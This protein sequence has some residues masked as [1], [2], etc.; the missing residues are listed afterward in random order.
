MATKLAIPSG[1]EGLPLKV[2]VAA[3]LA[4]PAGT[5]TPAAWA[6]TVPAALRIWKST[7]FTPPGARAVAVVCSIRPVKA[8]KAGLVISTVAT[9][10]SL[11]TTVTGSHS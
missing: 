11:Q 2:T 3:K 9:V 10:T 5:A 4:E 7:P 6:S 8:F 1:G